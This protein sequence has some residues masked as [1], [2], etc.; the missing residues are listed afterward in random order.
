MFYPIEK[1]NYELLVRLD[2]AGAVGDYLAL[3]EL[4]HWMIDH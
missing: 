1:S 2:A 4:F 3:T